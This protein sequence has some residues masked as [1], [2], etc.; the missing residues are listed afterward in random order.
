MG[1]RKR[2]DV[3]LKVRVSYT[4]AAM[5]DHLSEL[6]GLDRS[7]LIRNMLTVDAAS[8]LMRQAAAGELEL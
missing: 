2:F 4:Q 8:T 5:L 6:L 3:T 1:R 7:E